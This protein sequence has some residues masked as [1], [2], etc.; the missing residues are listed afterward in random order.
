MALATFIFLT[1]LQ[2]RPTSITFDPLLISR[3]ITHALERQISESA[4]II[5][6]VRVGYLALCVAFDCGVRS[7]NTNVQELVTLVSG[8]N[9]DMLNLLRLAERFCTGTFFYALIIITLVLIFINVCLVSISPDWHEE[10]DSE[11]S[12]REVRPFPSRLV[13]QCALSINV[14][15]S[16]LGLAFT[17]W[18][19][20]GDA[21]A[22]TLIRLLTYDLVTAQVSPLAGLQLGSTLSWQAALSACIYKLRVS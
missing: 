13:L 10:Q 5:Q 22:S 12:A 7:C 17:F 4:K 19:H 3:N 2:E 6:G 15:A 18:Q 9:G 1:F 11:S 20:I 21:G 16:L 8:G 14:L